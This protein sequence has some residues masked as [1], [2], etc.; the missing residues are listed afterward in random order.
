MRCSAEDLK[1]GQ[2]I[3]KELV[4]ISDIT[5]PYLMDVFEY[6]G[7]LRDDKFAPSLLEF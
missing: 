6:W 4:D 3:Q 5:K 1:P 2:W 7:R